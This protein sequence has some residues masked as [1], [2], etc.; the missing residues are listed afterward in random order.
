[1]GGIGNHKTSKK[2]RGRDVFGTEPCGGETCESSTTFSFS[3]TSIRERE[4]ER[5][6]LM[7]VER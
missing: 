1:M 2:V 7:D 6:P 3:I 5:E 4:R